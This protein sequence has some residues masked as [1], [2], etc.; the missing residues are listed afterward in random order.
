MI[1]K[2]F[3]SK[4]A[5]E[6][7]E[8]SKDAMYKEAADKQ[9]VNAITSAVDQLKRKM[10]TKEQFSERVNAI[11]KMFDLKP[12]DKVWLER[13]LKNNM[14]KEFGRVEIPALDNAPRFKP[15][16]SQSV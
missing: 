16:F 8:L 6:M 4:L 3:I 12:F 14:P 10:I 13:F 5:D 9:L 15:S 7:I 2:K 11:S 1:S